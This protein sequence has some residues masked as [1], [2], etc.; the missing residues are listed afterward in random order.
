MLK[1]PQSRAA[2]GLIEWSQAKLA[3]KS[4]VSISTI[5]DFE[6]GK[7][8]PFGNNLAAIRRAFESAG[9][10]FI[11]ENDD[12]IGVRMILC[13]ARPMP[14][15]PSEAIFVGQPKSAADAHRVVVGVRRAKV[16]ANGGRRSGDLNASD[17]D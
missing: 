16:R 11:S 8:S 7:R 1:A 15:A 4:G 5:R 9:V 10:A 2:R 17:D 12:V 14:S 6:A 13:K 3:E